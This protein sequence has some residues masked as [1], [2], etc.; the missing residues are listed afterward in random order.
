MQ[1][2]PT[3]NPQCKSKTFP[4]PTPKTRRSTRS[5][6]TTKWSRT[7]CCHK[8]TGKYRSNTHKKSARTSSK[9]STKTIRMTPSS[10][11]SPMIFS[12]K[13]SKASL[14]SNA[15]TSPASLIL[16]SVST[17]STPKHA[18]KS[19]PHSLPC[20]DWR[21]KPQSLIPWLKAGIMETL[22]SKTKKYHQISSPN[23]HWE[24][25]FIKYPKTTKTKFTPTS[26]SRSFTFYKISPKIIPSA[27]KCSN[28]TMPLSNPSKNT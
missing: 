2:F 9:F 13:S 26:Q 23:F 21:L 5:A 20:S 24:P 15:K 14:S 8:G 11:K 25:T 19:S 16:S 17:W 7:K 3:M 10:A 22:K 6:T 1:K 18:P 12:K 4:Q 27:C 28:L